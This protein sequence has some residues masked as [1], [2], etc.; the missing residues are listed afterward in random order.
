M[1]YICSCVNGFSE[2]AVEMDKIKLKGSICVQSSLELLSFND[3]TSDR[4]K[5]I[6][7]CLINI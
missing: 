3:F 5:A 4:A 1:L 6:W 2:G 7:P